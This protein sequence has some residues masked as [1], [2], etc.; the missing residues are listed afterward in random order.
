MSVRAMLLSLRR[1]EIESPEAVRSLEKMWADHRKAH[2]L[3]LY[4]KPAVSAGKGSSLASGQT[5]REVG[6]MGRSVN[7]AMHQPKRWD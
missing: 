6:T 7:K 2:D 5:V 3:D 4:G 1:F